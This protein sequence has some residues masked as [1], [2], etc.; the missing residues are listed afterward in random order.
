MKEE[1]IN[2]GNS[3]KEKII[4]NQLKINQN[5]FI[6][7]ETVIQLCNIS[8]V[9]VA[10]APK[11]SYKLS[12]LGMV[13]IGFLLLLTKVVIL[14]V[15]GLG[16]MILGSWLLYKT[17]LRNQDLGEYLVLNLNSGRDIYLYSKNHE[18][19]IE[20]MDVIINCVNSGREYKI[21]MENCQIESC[22][23]G[24]GNMLIGKDK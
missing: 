23:V 20:I 12:H 21:N 11:E 15:A 10:N 17:Y 19:T 8:R 13:F 14:I 24:D 9:S 5:V 4:T 6:Y 3:Q 1:K 16:I 18:F 2:I 7:N 22:Q